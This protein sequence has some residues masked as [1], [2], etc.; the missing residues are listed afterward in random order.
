MYFLKM[1]ANFKKYVYT[2]LAQELEGKI[3]ATEK[4]ALASKESI[5]DMKSAIEAKMKSEA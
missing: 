5:T 2:E 1:A 3:I 4:Y